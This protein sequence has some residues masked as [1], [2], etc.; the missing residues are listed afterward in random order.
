M[1]FDNDR[2]QYLRTEAKIYHLDLTRAK[3]RQSAE[4]GYVV[5]LDKPLFDLGTILTEVPS[6]VPV[7][8]A[9]AAEGTML[10]WCLKIQRA[11]RQRARFGNRCGWSTDQ[12]N[13]RPLEAEEIAEYKARIK[14]NA[15]VARLQAQ[16]TEVLETTAKDARVKAAH[17]DLQAR[18]GLSVKQPADSTLCSPALNAPKRKPVSRNAK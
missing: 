1:N 5:H 10:E 12:I 2:L 8:S 4:G 17:D 15:D 18:Y 14:H 11:E 9:A 16:L 6:S 3:L 13:R 7:R